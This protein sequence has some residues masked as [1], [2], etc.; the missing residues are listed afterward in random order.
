MPNLPTETLIPSQTQ[1][2]GEQVIKNVLGLSQTLLFALMDECIK[3]HSAL[4]KELTDLNN[5]LNHANLA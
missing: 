5:L 2:D 1:N 4:F 3:R